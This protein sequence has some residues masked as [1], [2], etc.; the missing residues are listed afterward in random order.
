MNVRILE[1][2]RLP[3][4]VDGLLAGWRVVGPRASNGGWMFDEIRAGEEVALEYTTTILPPKKAL[5]PT[6]QVLF[7]YRDGRPEIRRS[8]VPTVL[9]GVHSCDLHALALLDRAF[10]VGFPDQPYRAQRAETV[11]VGLECLQP[12]SEHAFCK[13]M[14]TLA[15]PE[16]VDLH[17]IDLGA[18][19]AIEVGTDLGRELVEDT[20]SLRPCR[21]EE[22][23]QLDRVVGEKW[24]RFS[25]RLDFDVT[26]LPSLMDASRDSELWA[27][28]AERCLGCGACTL[29]CPTCTCFDVR[30]EMDL[31]LETGARVRTWD[32]CQLASFAVVA[33]GHNF[34]PDRAARLR[35][36]FLRKGNYQTRAF[37]LPGCVGCGCCAQAC[38]AGITPIETYNAL[39]RRIGEPR[40]S[41]TEVPG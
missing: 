1:K 11:L 7:G 24:P 16:D 3:E 30:D 14:G 34:R 28:L 35:H 10:G 4:W 8:A 20:A 19:Y 12:C 29:V 22:L 5:L 33:G 38:L 2:A 23:D 21:D 41:A 13:S 15:P 26:Q 18:A 6:R 9:L 40:P 39:Y 27:E 31:S 32:S 37:G 17:L 36:R 25:H